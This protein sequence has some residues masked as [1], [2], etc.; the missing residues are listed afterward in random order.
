MLR[1]AAVVGRSVRGQ[2]RKARYEQMLSALRLIADMAHGGDM[3]AKGHEQPLDEFFPHNL[4]SEQAE[5]QNDLQPS[6]DVLSARLSTREFDYAG[7]F[8]SFFG[9]EFAEGGRGP[10]EH[11]SAQIGE[12]RLHL[13]V[14]ETGVYLLVELADYLVGRISG[15][16]HAVPV[17]CLIAGHEFGNGWEIRQASE[18][19]A[20]VTASARSVPALMY[21]IDEGT[22]AKMT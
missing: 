14:G 21:S 10:S 13:G 2:V 3:V 6:A 4:L 17:A 1:E 16:P 7:P 9:N 15:R 19:V 5:W 11:R 20:L 22:V 12:P 18:R 8:L